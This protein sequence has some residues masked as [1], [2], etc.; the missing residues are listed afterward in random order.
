MIWD[1]ITVI[2]VPVALFY[3]WLLKRQIK[4]HRAANLALEKTIRQ[5]E[6]QLSVLADHADKLERQNKAEE[7]MRTASL[8]NFPEFGKPA[9]PSGSDPSSH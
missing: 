8:V 4:Q 2:T 5:L 1:W 6:N 7:L 9:P 3:G